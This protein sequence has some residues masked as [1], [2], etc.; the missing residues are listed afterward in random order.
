MRIVVQRA[1]YAKCIIDGQVHSSISR[2]F[3]AFVGFEENDTED[4]LPKLAHKLQGLR[5]FEDENGK[6]NLG[7]RDVGGSILSISQFTLYADS[8]HGF[9]PSF[10]KA[11]EPVRANEYYKK[12]NNI[13]RDEYGINV[14]EGVFGAHMKITFTNDGPVTIILD[15]NDL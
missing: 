4:M 13:I 10:V 2:G 6:M 15:S 7:L 14:A 9:R 1:F 12:F 5:V 11:M 8:K 3:V